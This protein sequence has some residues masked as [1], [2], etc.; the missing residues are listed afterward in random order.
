VRSRYDGSERR[1]KLRIAGP[2][3]AVV[4]GRN[5]K[6]E[7]FETDAVLDNL[8][9]G[10]LYVRLNPRLESGANL[11]VIIRFS[12]TPKDETASARLAVRGVVCRVERQEAGVW[13]TAVVFKNH[14]F[15]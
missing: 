1:N 8:S 5:E 2:F 15:L 6:G 9:A 11:F 3:P 12:M 4:R 14:R 13:G 10:G 7:S